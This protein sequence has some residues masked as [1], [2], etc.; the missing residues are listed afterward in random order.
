MNDNKTNMKKNLFFIAVVATGLAALIMGGTSCSDENDE[1]NTT[2]LRYDFAEGQ[3]GTL[4]FIFGERQTLSMQ[5]TDVDYFKLKHVP[6]SWTVLATTD[7]LSVRSPSEKATSYDNEGT[8]EL[9][10]YNRTSGDSVSLSFD[11]TIHPDAMYAVSFEE[12]SDYVE[13]FTWGETKEYPFTT[14]NIRNPYVNEIEGWTIQIDE[15][16]QIVYVTAPE[17]SEQQLFTVG[18]EVILSAYKSD[19]EGTVSDFLPVSLSVYKI[20][21]S[22]LGD[23]KLYEVYNEYRD[24]VAIIA[25]EYI[26]LDNEITVLYPFNDGYEEG[27]VF[28]NGGTIAFNHSPYNPGTQRVENLIFSSDGKFFTSVTGEPLSVSIEESLITD[29]EGNTYSLL[30]ALE[31]FWTNENLYVKT[32]FSGVEL[33][34]YEPANYQTVGLLYNQA[35]TLNGESTDPVRG[36]CPSGWHIPGDTEFEIYVNQPATLYNS[37]ADTF[38][39]MALANG[40]YMG[41]IG[42]FNSTGV[43][44][45]VMPAMMPGIIAPQSAAYNTYYK[46]IRC[47]KDTVLFK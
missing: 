47:I 12:N 6:E 37:L 4:T 38:G 27:F 1:R 19:I 22:G 43:P 23:K 44:Y 14:R 11:V 30:K 34:Y 28:T 7:K 17:Y 5:G 10:A 21:I 15:T 29:H 13:I 26:T 41:T 45:Q 31:L 18:G 8:V 25:R 2:Q 35:T 20:D 9:W 24:G 32:D 16:E 42:L 40:T 39:G 3:P 33:D 46:N 36:L